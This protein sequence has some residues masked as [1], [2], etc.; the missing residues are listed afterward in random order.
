[1]AVGISVRES[2]MVKPAVETPRR[3]LWISNLDMVSSNAHTPTVYFYRPENG[4]AVDNGNFFDPIELKEALSK[5]LVPFYPLAGRLQRNNE[6]KNGRV[7]IDCNADGV[8]FVFADSSYC[9][10]DF[11]DFLPTPEFGS[12]LIPDVDYSA[13][14][15]SYA[16]LVVQITYLKCGGVVLGIGF[17]HCVADGFS[18]LHFINAWS[19]MARGLDLAI[20]PNLDRTLLR[21]REPPQPLLHHNH[22]VEYQ[23]APL[24][25]T[26]ATAG[27]DPDYET[28]TAT[29][30]SIFK[31]TKE[32]INILKAKSS[33][34][35]GNS[36]MKYTSYEVFAAHVW[37]CA[38]KARELADDQE[39]QFHIAANGR[40]RLQSPIPPGYFGN[41]IFCGAPTAFAGDIIS[42]PIGYAASCIHNTL[43]RMDD[44]YLRSALDYL[45][46]QQSHRHLSDFARGAHYWKCPNLGITSWVTLPIYDA[47]FRWGRPIFVGRG[48]ILHEG[49]A[50]T[51]PKAGNDGSFSLAINCS[52]Q[53]MKSFSKLIYEI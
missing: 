1:M 16:L 43:V 46:L 11:G 8:L 3:S 10:D 2:I 13:G 4:G 48:K 51:I 37:R 45:E 31:F 21:A 53:H 25:T 52:A 12:M 49:K 42:K 14:I 47:D 41:V 18:A 39:T 28:A 15:S 5:A 6:D 7:E 35:D 33:N 50:Y 30:V 34:D 17:E 38:C 32:H 29:T 27:A 23:P 40:S 22:H 20:P 44:D 24:P 26:E 36:S 9:I 19:D